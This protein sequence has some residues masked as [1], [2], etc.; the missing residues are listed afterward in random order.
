MELWVIALGAATA[1]LTF[2]LERNG[3]CKYTPEIAG[4]INGAVLATISVDPAVASAA[5]AML[6]GKLLAGEEKE[7]GDYL[8]LA[9]YFLLFVMLN[10]YV[11]LIPATIIAAGAFAD[12]KFAKEHGILENRILTHVAAAAMTPLIGWGAIITTLFYDCTY[13]IAALIGKG[14]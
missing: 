9:T 2:F 10:E 14:L 8:A 11:Y 3:K 12:S 5:A 13:R 1:G 6:V 4:T 7:R